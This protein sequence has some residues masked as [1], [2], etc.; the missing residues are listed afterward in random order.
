MV[1]NNEKPISAVPGFESVTALDISQLSQM[2]VFPMRIRRGTGNLD[3]FTLV[4]VPAFHSVE[5]HQEIL[6]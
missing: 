5:E 1:V 3:S 2:A 4:F 6:G